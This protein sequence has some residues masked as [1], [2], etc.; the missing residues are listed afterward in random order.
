MR[1]TLEQ[2]LKFKRVHYCTGFLQR[3]HAIKPKMADQAQSCNEKKSTSVFRTS[4]FNIHFYNLKK[5]ILNT[6]MDPIT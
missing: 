3:P 4:V 5:I 6:G 1:C 2:E